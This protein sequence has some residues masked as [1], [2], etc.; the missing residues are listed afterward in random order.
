LEI[1]PINPN[2][3]PQTP[4]KIPSAPKA[5]MREIRDALPEYPWT[6]KINEAKKPKRNPLTIASFCV[7]EKYPIVNPT[8]PQGIK[9]KT[10]PKKN[11]K[12]FLKK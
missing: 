7:F 8:T 11:S 3:K 6:I 12:I 4:P 10:D 5:G 1:K 2:T 9:I